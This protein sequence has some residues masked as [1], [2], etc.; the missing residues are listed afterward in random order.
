MTDSAIEQNFADAA[1]AYDEHASVQRESAADLLDFTLPHRAETAFEPGCGTGIYTGL[2]LE[3]F[4]KAKLLC[5]DIAEDMLEVARSKYGHAASFRRADA[6]E[7]AEGPWDLITSNATF[8]WFNDLEETLSR[9]RG[10]LQPGGLLTFS[11]FGPRTYQELDEALNR[12]TDGKRRV[13]ASGFA[14]RQRIERLLDQNFPTWSVQEQRYV[15]AYDSLGDLLSTIKYTGV[16]GA[17]RPAASG[18]SLPLISQ[19]RRE[20]R[21]SFGCIRASYQVFLC[22]GEI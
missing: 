2:L 1:L 17:P 20:Y 12:A 19:T 11:F 13:A 16:R 21:Q 15:R 10:M 3:A 18:W 7:M 9:Y 6:E 8:Q 14:D 4:P 22:R 5:V